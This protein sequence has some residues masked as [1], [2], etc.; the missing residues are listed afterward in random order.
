MIFKDKDKKINRLLSITTWLVIIASWY[1]FTSFAGKESGLLPSPTEVFSAFSVILRDG[2][3][4]I[5]LSQ[6]LL[7][8]FRR[9]F[10][11]VGAAGLIA[12]PTG[13]LSGYLPKVRAVID[14][15][16]QFYRPIP[17][18]AY[19]ALLIMWLGIE[20]ESKISLL[21]LAA[22]A[23]IYIA[24]ASAVASINKDYILSARSLGASQ[25]DIFFKIILPASLPD[26]LTSLRTSLGFAFTTLVA[27][28]MTAATSGIGWMV[29]DASRYLKSDVMFVGIII[30]GIFGVLM[31]SGLKFVENKI[32]YWKGKD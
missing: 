26:I 16:V 5:A 3:N 28:E 23:P 12:V 20:D 27:A 17:P 18:L 4:G 15:L 32:V 30:M 2:Y 7:D 8:S 29:I 13:L 10:I 31:D 14:S 22:F 21:F 11:A 24:G 9:L 6:H 19:Y 1:I 25:K